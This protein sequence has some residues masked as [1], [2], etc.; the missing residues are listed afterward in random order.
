MHRPLAH[1]SSLCLLAMLLVACSTFMRPTS[2]EEPIAQRRF[3][4]ELRGL[5]PSQLERA[6]VVL[7]EA[8]P[9]GG[10]SMRGVCRVGRLLEEARP[11][12]TGTVRFEVA[13]RRVDLW[14][15]RVDVPDVGSQ[16]FL[17]AGGA[18]DWPAEAPVLQAVWRPCREVSGT[19]SASDSAAATVGLTAT[20]FPGLAVH[21]QEPFVYTRDPWLA[22]LPWEVPKHPPGAR[23][24][25][26]LGPLRVELD[27]KTWRVRKPV[28]DGR[29]VALVGAWGS[30]WEYV[31]SNGRSAGVKVRSWS[32]QGLRE[33][34][35]VLTLEDPLPRLG[36]LD[37][38]LAPYAVAPERVAMQPIDPDRRLWRCR[39]HVRRGEG[40]SSA[41]FLADPE[42]PLPLEVPADKLP[43]GAPL[44]VRLRDGQLRPGR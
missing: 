21:A 43:D 42:A 25:S 40:L 23:L 41:L 35:V 4:I 31:E 24:T 34:E 26:A 14:A 16:W 2:A 3:V 13:A 32:E 37:V 44:F 18:G 28:G 7:H 29:G 10:I 1:P 22:G 33:V 20:W 36:D 39:F 30:G 17:I 11:D 5:Q 19:W 12:A 9:S 8:E 15:C 27:G 38:L 6:T